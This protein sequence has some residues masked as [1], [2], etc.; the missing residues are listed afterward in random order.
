[1]L[2]S[3]TLKWLAVT[4]VSR[5]SQRKIVRSATGKATPAG[6]RQPE[7]PGQQPDAKQSGRRTAPAG[8]L[9]T[10]PA[11]AVRARPCAAPP[12]SPART[13]A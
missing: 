4:L 1:M 9:D 10:A 2:S 7:M 13:D 11:L 5:L 12:P 3:G 8:G 6:S